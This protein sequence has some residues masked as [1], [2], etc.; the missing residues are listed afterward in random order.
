MKERIY[1]GFS[2]EPYKDD[3]GSE[4]YENLIDQVEGNG[5]SLFPYKTREDAYEPEV[6][7]KD[8][9]MEF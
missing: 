9:D 4:D 5:G 3:M 2:E 8:E 6:W 1:D 7:D